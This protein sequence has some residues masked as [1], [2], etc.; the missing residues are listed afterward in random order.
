MSKFKNVSSGILEISF[1]EQH[2]QSVSI[3][4]SWVTDIRVSDISISRMHALLVRHHS[5]YILED[6][7]STN[8]TFVNN[9]RI[10][11][12]TL[13]KPSDRIRLGKVILIIKENI[14]AHAAC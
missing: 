13:I 10:R 2:R 14:M 8:G 9:K 3:G 12:P 5:G 6:L 4:R 11:T 7:G 1:N